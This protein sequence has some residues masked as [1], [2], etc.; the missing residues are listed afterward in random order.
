M[1]AITQY[2]KITE[3]NLLCTSVHY[4]PFDPVHGLK[5]SEEEMVN[6]GYLLVDNIPSPEAKIGMDS[7]LHYNPKQDNFWYEYFDV[8]L[9]EDE[10]MSELE[11]E[12]LE[13]KLALAEMAGM[14]EQHKLETQLA[15]AELA[16]AMAGGVE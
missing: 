1:N 7:Q 13:L 15:L 3:E 2:T 11:T 12:N 9:T 6:R 14:Q 16:E 5:I 10:R 8:P 4:C